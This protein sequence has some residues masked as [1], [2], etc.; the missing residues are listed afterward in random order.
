MAKPLRTDDPKP[1]S[2][3]FTHFGVL[4][5]GQQSKSSLI[6]SITVNVIVAIIVCILGGASPEADRASEAEGSAEAS[7]SASHRQASTPEDYCSGG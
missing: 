4:H 7:S 6:T 2:V 3:Q 1:Q 5:D